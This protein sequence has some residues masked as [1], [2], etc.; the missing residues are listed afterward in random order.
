MRVGS[1]AGA[2]SA[3]SYTHGGWQSLQRPAVTRRFPP[4]NTCAGAFFPPLPRATGLSV[5]GGG[6]GGAFGAGGS[7]T[8]GLSCI[9]MIAS[10]IARIPSKTGGGGLATFG[11]FS[12]GGIERRYAEIARRSS[13]AS[14]GRY[15]EGSGGY[16]GRA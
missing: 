11:E 16:S 5:I 12:M 15:G 3:G 13:S 9:A 6:G 7:L 14:W 10:F 8:P 4:S 2:A 1:G